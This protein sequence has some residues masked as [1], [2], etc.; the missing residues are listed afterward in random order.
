MKTKAKKAPSCH[1]WQCTLLEVAIRLHHLIWV[2]KPPLAILGLFS[3]CCP[4]VPLVN[5]WSSLMPLSVLTL[6]QGSHFGHGWNGLQ[7][8]TGPGEADHTSHLSI[9]SSQ[10]MDVLSLNNINCISLGGSESDLLEC[11]LR[12]ESELVLSI[13]VLL[14]PGTVAGTLWRNICWLKEWNFLRLPAVAGSA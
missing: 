12:E 5:W 4:A 3:G 10:E 7:D 6:G 13:S 8:E 11:K 9:F 14:V 1:L 2:F